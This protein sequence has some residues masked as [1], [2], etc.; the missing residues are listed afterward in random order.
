MNPY[1]LYEFT[2]GK[3]NNQP[4]LFTNPINILQADQLDEIPVIFEKVENAL[5][6]GYHVA[7][8][9]SYEAAPAFDQHLSVQSAHKLPLL[10]LGVFEAPQQTKTENEDGN[11]SLS[12]WKMDG[13]IQQYKNGIQQIRQ[14]IEDGNTYQVNYTARLCADFEGDDQAFYR[15]LTRNQQSNY[16][17]YLNIGKYRILS[18]S[19]ELFFRVKQNNIQTKPMKGTAARGRTTAEDNVQKEYLRHSIKEQSENLMIVDLLRNDIGR[20]AKPGT[21]TVP[22]LFELETYPT[23]HQMTSTVE[24]ELEDSISVFDWFRALFPCGSITGAPKRSTMDYISELEDSPREV[25]CGAIG[26]ITPEREAV[27]N[28]PIRT[29]V[30]DTEERVA[31]YGVGG[32][33]TWDSTAEGE[34]QEL[35]TKA[36]LLTERRPAFK[37]LESLKLEDGIYPLL[38]LHL[39]RLADSADYFG[40]RLEFVK[41]EKKLEKYAQANP[42]GNYKVRLLSADDGSIVL[43]GKEVKHLSGPVRCAI[44]RKPVDQHDPFLFHKTTHRENYEKHLSGLTPD[45]FSVLLWNEKYELTEFTIGN[46][47]VEMQGRLYTPPLSSGLLAGTFRRQLLEKNE[48]K[49]KIL[50]LH[51]IPQFDHVWLIN[52]VRGWVEVNLE[53]PRTSIT[54]TG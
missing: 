35:L 46:I 6:A 27:F 43:E 15:Q 19:P 54:G 1:L 40:F 23:V 10:W 31:T 53:Q 5:K 52:G 25:Y 36:R 24:A 20:I 48:I 14:A 45:I 7:G 41:I 8:Y 47:V 9:I 37:L 4:L 38:S 51:E 29:V 44:A 28:V 26:Y 16:S 33:V 21:V 49:E 13:S 50:Y 22:K 30:I 3:K 12:E 39:E 34:Y 2:D 42:T 17:A 18:A 32:G 11:F